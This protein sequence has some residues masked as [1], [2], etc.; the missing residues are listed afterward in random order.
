MR[1][2][3][4]HDFWFEDVF[5][6]DE[7][8]LRESPEVQGAPPDPLTL[9]FFFPGFS[10]FAAMY[11]GIADAAFKVAKEVLAERKPVGGGPSALAN[12]GLQS[13]LGEID[14]RL[15]EASAHLNWTCHLYRDSRTWTIANLPD[16]MAMK[17]SVTRKAVEITEMCMQAVGGPAYY[18]RVPLER[19][20]R[21]VR[22]GPIH[23][24]QHPAAMTA[25]GGAIARQYVPEQGP[26]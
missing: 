24:P 23:P 12:P 13:F 15:R 5:V 25:L 14:Q 20:Y 9:N 17:D 18:T 16:V 7:N 11:L 1:G 2:S 6:P 21:D 22:G 8:V 19:L 10:L 3:N 26:A 4:S